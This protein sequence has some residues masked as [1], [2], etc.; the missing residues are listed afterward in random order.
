[1]ELETSRKTI[2]NQSS[3]PSY[4]NDFKLENSLFEAAQQVLFLFQGL[5]NYTLHYDSVIAKAV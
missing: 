5:L 2:S 3:T 1:M 4:S